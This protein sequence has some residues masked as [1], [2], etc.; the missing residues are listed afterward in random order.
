MKLKLTPL[1]VTRA[2]LAKLIRFS[3]RHIQNLERAGVIPAVKLSHRAVRYD[4]AAVVSAL[5]ARF[6]IKSK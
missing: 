4:A 6:E 2:E 5:K 1:L 3:P